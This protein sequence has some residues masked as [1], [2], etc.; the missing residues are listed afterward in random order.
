MKQCEFLEGG[1]EYLDENYFIKNL[2]HKI[3]E[4]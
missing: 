1:N 3:G 4:D 2:F